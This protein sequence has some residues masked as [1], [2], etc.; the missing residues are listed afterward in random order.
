MKKLTPEQK[1]EIKQEK[2]A[3]KS[4]LDLIQK[5]KQKGA[6]VSQNTKDTLTV[7]II[8]IICLLGDYLFN[9]C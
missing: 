7:T 3:T 8:L 2:K 6:L 4:L 5:A 1:A 9:L